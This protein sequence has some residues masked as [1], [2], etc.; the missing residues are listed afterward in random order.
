MPEPTTITVAVFY[1]LGDDAD[2][3]V[4]EL[5]K[6]FS[7]KD[8]ADHMGRY[9]SSYANLRVEE[10]TERLDAQHPAHLPVKAAPRPLPQTS[11]LK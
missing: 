5:G 4:H 11:S 8:A 1:I 6:F 3:R 9:A 10:R 7:Q 2:R